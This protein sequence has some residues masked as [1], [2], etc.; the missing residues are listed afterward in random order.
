MILSDGEPELKIQVKNP[1]LWR[2]NLF[3]GSKPITWIWLQLREIF[4]FL[5][6]SNLYSL[7][8]T[9][10]SSK[11]WS[12]VIAFCVSGVMSFFCSE[13]I[14]AFSRNPPICVSRFK[15]SVVFIFFLISFFVMLIF[16]DLFLS[17]RD[18]TTWIWKIIMWQLYFECRALKQLVEETGNH[19]S[20][21]VNDQ[22]AELQKHWWV[23]NSWRL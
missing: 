17:V 14:S 18:A 20:R 4:S 23:K 19:S 10:W 9:A 7:S 13:I 5:F 22:I 16:L 6:S 8:L 3:L 21:D 11:Y 12:L 1:Q 2:V 15:Q